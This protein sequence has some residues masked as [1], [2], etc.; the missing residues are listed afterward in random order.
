MSPRLIAAALL[1]VAHTASAGEFKYPGYTYVA[2]SYYLTPPVYYA[3][4]APPPFAAPVQ[5]YAPS[6]VVGSSVIAHEPAFLHTTVV[7]YDPVWNYGGVL[8]GTAYRERASARP[9]DYEYT[10]KTFG[11]PGQRYR[12][13]VEVD[14]NDIEVRQRYR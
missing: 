6:R 12:Y 11:P 7:P 10:L 8:P 5:V 2:P 1:C 3:P 14:P 9:R 4:F 13:K